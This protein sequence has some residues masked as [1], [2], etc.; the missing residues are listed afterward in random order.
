VTEKA[1]IMPKQSMFSLSENQGKS[2]LLGPTLASITRFSINV[3]AAISG[4]AGIGIPQL[5]LC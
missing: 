2:S 3:D 5:K 4:L 1:K